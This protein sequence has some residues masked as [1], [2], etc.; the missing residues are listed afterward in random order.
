[1]NSPVYQPSEIGLR[2]YPT[3]I[4]QYYAHD[5]SG[6]ARSSLQLKAQLFLRQNK[7]KGSV[8]KKSAK[9]IKNAVNWLAA[10][11][12]MKRIYSKIDNRN[13]TFRMNFITLTL[14]SLDHGITD[15]NFKNKL[16]RTWL[17]RMRYRHG[18]R[19][20]VWKVETQAN[21]NIHAHITTDCFIHYA[22]IREAW[23]DI[24]IKN[25]LMR[26][27]ADNHGHSDP[28]STDV[29]A[30]KRIK[31]LAAY[32]AKYFSKSDEDRRKVSGRLWSSSYSLSDRNVCNIIVP[33]DDDSGV[34]SPLVSSKAD[35]VYVES[36]PNALG[37][38][39]RLATVYFMRKQDWRSLEGTLIFT[40]Y[41]NR[42]K[43]IQTGIPVDLKDQFNF[44]Q[45][46]HVRFNS[47]TSNQRTG[48]DPTSLLCSDRTHPETDYV[49]PD[50]RKELRQLD[51]FQPI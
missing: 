14:P 16:L 43:E 13:Y 12:K 39:R 32:L 1:M 48:G 7:H 23:N 19:N 50:E 5:R 30:V 49:M 9:R 38:R 27:F 51:L 28:N 37:L 22:E 8:S 46:E 40:H 18:L 29:K 44:N 36:E 47:T 20:Y 11:S 17:E 26:T 24:L 21:G 3:H 4:V 45:L 15:H 2:I 34:V 25:G 41:L 35:C 10:S 31:N 42:I 6:R 33:P